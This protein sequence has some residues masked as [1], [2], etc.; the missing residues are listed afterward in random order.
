MFID[1]LIRGISINRF[2]IFRRRNKE[3]ATDDVRVGK[4][5]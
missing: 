1:V 3:Q 4:N 5:P 2:R